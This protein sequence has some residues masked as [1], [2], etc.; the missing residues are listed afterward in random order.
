MRDRQ[1]AFADTER[2]DSY[3]AFQTLDKRRTFAE[4]DAVR[5]PDDFHIWCRAKKALDQRQG[6]TAVN[7]ERLRLD[8]FDLH[9]SSACKTEGNVARGLRQ[10]QDRDAATISFGARDHLVGGS[11]ARVPGRRRGPA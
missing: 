3:D 1:S 2:V 6:C 7:A 9:A 5:Q 11:Q 8:L 4:V 10:R